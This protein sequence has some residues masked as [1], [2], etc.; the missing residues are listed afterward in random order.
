MFLTAHL[1][2]KS[3][4]AITEDLGAQSSNMMPRNVRKLKPRVTF[5]W[6][7]TS[8]IKRKL[9]HQ[10]T[11]VCCG[12]VKANT[13]KVIAERYR[14]VVPEIYADRLARGV[15]TKTAE[16]CAHKNVLHAQVNIFGG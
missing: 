15:W 12:S 14:R 2:A 13:S 1:I 9:I 3:I 4:L 16:I 10:A 8:E 7:K 11:T 6:A 5:V